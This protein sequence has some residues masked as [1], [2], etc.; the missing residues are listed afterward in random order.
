LGSLD[1]EIRADKTIKIRAPT[2]QSGQS[3]SYLSTSDLD[4]T[5]VPKRKGELFL[6]VN[7]AVWAFD[8]GKREERDSAKIEVTFVPK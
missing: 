2:V 3:P 4:V 1:F 7:D 5:I 8:K 6:C